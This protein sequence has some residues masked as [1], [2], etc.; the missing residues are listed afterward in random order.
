MKILYLARCFD[1]I[2]F[3]MK[4][5]IQTA[6]RRLGWNGKNGKEDGEMA[7]RKKKSVQEMGEF[8]KKRNS[9]SA[10]TFRSTVK[11]CILFGLVAQLVAL[12]FYSYS[13]T[14]QYVSIADSAAHQAAQSATH[15][16]DVI[17]FSDRVMKI[18]Q[19]LSEEE[20]GKMGTPEYRE[21]FSALQ[22]EKKG[23]L[24]DVL[25][26]MLAG[27]LSFY[28][29]Y[30]IYVGMYDRE[31]NVIV[32]VV[33]ADP[34]ENAAFYPGE[35]EAVS[36]KEVKKFLDWDGEGKLYHIGWTKAYGLLCTVGMPLRNVNG[37][38]VSYMLVDISVENVLLGLWEFFL[39]LT[40]SLVVVTILLAW[41]QTRRIHRTLVQPI[42]QI[43]EA[44]VK[45]VSDRKNN[46]AGKERFAKLNIHTGDELENL[47]LAM[48]D[49]ERELVDYEANLTRITAEKERIGTELALATQIQAAML[50]HVFP[51]FPNR[52]EFDLYAMMQPA[53]EVGGDF[54]DFFLIDEN[55]LCLVIADVS[56]KGIPAALFMMISK[57]ILQSCAML[58]NGAAETLMRMNEAL[59]SNNQVE[60]FVTV[61]IG[62]LE[63]STGKL[64]AANAGHEYP[65]LMRNNGEFELLKDKHGLVVGGMEGTR[66][67]EYELQ[68][69]PGDKLFVYTDGLPE[70][71]D[72]ENHMFGTERMLATLNQRKNATPDELIKG[73]YGAVGDFVKDAEQFDDLTML[74]MEYHGK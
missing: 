37:E 40:I 2:I 47:G 58:G 3:R 70:A 33:D 20:R 52:K 28:D 42:N 15:G 6:K 5:F 73:T 54:Y 50:P 60:M 25:V 44:S 64:T 34:D 63:I 56:G 23:S 46:K 8:E 35:W 59:C 51:P 61:W 65:A 36:P 29:V 10:K 57:T 62:I 14:R 17:G 30:D 66:Y 7:L 27:T 69:L 53:R 71:S 19:G 18:Y 4:F 16:S 24:H 72:S 68:L 41:L 26:H 31:N 22:I 38:I 43:A 39:Q 49:M 74:C 21:Y 13:L 67:K 9:L 45:Y 12:A 32:Y 11:S 1:K 48:A 55:H